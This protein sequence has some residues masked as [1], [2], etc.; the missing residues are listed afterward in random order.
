MAPG[1]DADLKLIAIRAA[2][3]TTIPRRATVSD[4]KI[5]EVRDGRHSREVPELS[6]AC[7]AVRAAVG[8]PSWSRNTAAL[9]DQAVGTNDPRAWEAACDDLDTGHFDVRAAA[10]AM[11]APRATSVAMCLS[12]AKTT[13]H[14]LWI[15]RV[16]VAVL[17]RAS[18]DA[19]RAAGAVMGADVPRL[20]GHVGRIVAALRREEREAVMDALGR[21]IA[22]ADVPGPVLDAALA[23][24]ARRGRFESLRLF[25]ATPVG[26][27]V[28]HAT[29]GVVVER[30]LE[31]S[32]LHRTTTMGIV[33]RCVTENPALAD[34]HK[35]RLSKLVGAAF[36]ARDL[37]VRAA[38][39]ASVIARATFECPVVRGIAAFT[40]RA[41]ADLAHQARK[42]AKPDL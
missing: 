5:C 29:F 12:S 19:M 10:A 6:K 35:S 11:D 7:E 27:Y 40:E 28:S 1:S 30:A 26:R 16:L 24:V 20:A 33:A 25:S 15:V 31:A 39:A 22:A 37:D 32:H 3:P 23:D 2:F 38:L 42:R 8:E 34:S 41:C 9:L 17:P 14:V 13:V 4:G 18:R 21:A 36:G